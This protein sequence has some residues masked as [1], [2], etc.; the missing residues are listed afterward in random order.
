MQRSASN[1]DHGRE[2]WARYTGFG[3]S[4]A[5]IWL[6]KLGWWAYLSKSQRPP[7]KHEGRCEPWWDSICFLKYLHILVLCRCWEPSSPV[8]KCSD[9][10]QCRGQAG[11]MKLSCV[12]PL[13]SPLRLLRFAQPI[14]VD[15]AGK[16]PGCHWQRGWTRLGNSFWQNLP[17]LFSLP[18]WLLGGYRV[19][20]VKHRQ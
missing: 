11:D 16:G 15:E 19:K 18:G 8:W 3:L 1:R 6:C 7:W 12:T 17:V 10:F 14:F 13:V 9:A 2:L 5:T 20:A 4:S